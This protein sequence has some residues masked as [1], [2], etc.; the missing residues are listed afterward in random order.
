MRSTPAL[1]LPDPLPNASSPSSSQRGRGRLASVTAP[2]LRLAS[3]AVRRERLASVAAL[4]LL[5][6]LAPAAVATARPGRLWFAPES[7]NG[8]G[9]NLRHPNWGR[10]G[11]PYRR[12]TPPRYADGAGAMVSSPSPR[13]VSNRIFNSDRV[14]LFSARYVSQWGWVWGQFLDHTFG[15]AQAGTQSD[16]IPFSSSDPLEAYRDDAGN[17]GFLRDAAAPGTGLSPSRPRQQ[18]NTLSSYIDASAVYGTSPSRLD[19][20]LQ[21]PDDGRLADSGAKLLLPHGYL[22]QAD[23]RGDWRRAP[24]MQADGLLQGDPQQ[25]VVAGDVRANDNAD[26][27]GVQTL[28]AREHNRIVSRLPRSLP[29]TSRFQIARR[30]LAAEEQYITYTQPASRRSPANAPSGSRPA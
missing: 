20:M 12:L 2:L 14:D 28:F 29:A 8:A 10:A 19:W 22:P 24:Y 13:Y 26:L 21:G 5:A 4:T 7:L 11:V 1:L 6:L 27:V 15:F 9:N 18:I 30:I 16:P 23:A 25:A 17:I 3:V